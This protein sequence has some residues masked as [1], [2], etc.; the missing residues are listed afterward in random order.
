MHG[1][2]LILPTPMI[3][4]IRTPVA[5]QFF[6]LVPTRELLATLILQCD[7][8]MPGDVGEIGFGVRTAFAESTDLDDYLGRTP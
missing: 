5:R 8:P 2:A 1:V 6:Q 4:N 7:F 3:F